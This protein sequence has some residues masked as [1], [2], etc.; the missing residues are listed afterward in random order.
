[1]AFNAY[2][3]NFVNTPGAGAK[4]NGNPIAIKNSLSILN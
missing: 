4:P 3:I 1:M 2:L